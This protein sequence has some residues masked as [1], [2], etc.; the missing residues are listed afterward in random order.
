MPRAGPSAAARAG[1]N[2]AGRITSPCSGRTPPALRSSFM[3]AWV[4]VAADPPGSAAQGDAIPGLYGDG[5][6]GPVGRHEELLAVVLVALP[7]PDGNVAPGTQLQLPRR[8]RAEIA[9]L[10]DRHAGHVVGDE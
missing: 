3:S 6:H 2:R 5:F 7:A 10:V 9:H 1:S 8:E 4:A